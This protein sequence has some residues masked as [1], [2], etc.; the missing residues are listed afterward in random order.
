MPVADFACLGKCRG[1]DGE[2]MVYELPVG[3]TRCSV[4]GSKRVRHLFNKIAVIG[5]REHA[6]E[7]DPR[8]TSSSPAVVK[9][10][11]L[12]PAF[13]HADQH[14][15][16]HKLRSW[17]IP[18]VALADPSYQS[19]SGRGRPMNELERAALKRHD[20]QPQNISNVLAAIAKQPIPS[21][22]A[23]R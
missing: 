21:T 18:N 7:T 15:P 13:D 16:S 11:L 20:P 10:A 3:S 4:C 6:P 2:A 5:T 1:P 19:K 9:D 8:L 23:G 17:A 22:V 14:K 12:T